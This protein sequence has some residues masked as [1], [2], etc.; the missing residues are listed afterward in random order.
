MYRLEFLD[1]NAVRFQ[2]AVGQVGDTVTA[3]KAFRRAI[4]HTGDKARTKVRRSLAKQMGLTQKRLRQLDALH[5]RR[6]N[7]GAL[8]YTITG[9]GKAISLK[10]FGARQFRY[11]VRARPWGQ[12]RRFEGTFIFAG[13]P[14]SGKFVAGGHVFKRTSGASLPIEK[15]WGPSVPREL[16]QA[17]SLQAFE[18][19]ARYLGPRIVHELRKLTDGTVS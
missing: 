12:S 10:E 18:D 4:N 8:E 6:A 17:A 1:Q 7:F 2:E 16:V 14:R 3:H 13:N 9:S 15:L 19:T 5:T 11:G